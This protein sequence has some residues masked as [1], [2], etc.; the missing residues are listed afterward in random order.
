MRSDD[1][2]RDKLDADTMLRAYEMQ[3]K[4]GTQVDVASIK[5]MMERDREALRN[6]QNQQVQAQ[7]A[8][9]QQA[10]QMNMGM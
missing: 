1:L 7:Q 3:L 6:M 10:Q 2:D 9:V 8:Q 4:Y 5:A